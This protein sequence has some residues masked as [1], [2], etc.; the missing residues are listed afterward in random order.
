[1][2]FG[3]RLGLR[4]KIALPF[5]ITAVA[6]VVIGLFAVSTVR[7]L[8]SDTDNIADTYLPSVS[9]ILN[10]DRDL[11]QALVAQMAYVDAQSNNENGE[12]YLA[13][14]DEN[15]GQA[16]DRFNTAVGRLE[17]TGVSDVARGFDAAYERWLGSAQRVL[18]LAE[19]GTR[20]RQEP[21]QP[22]KPTTSS[23][24]SEITSTRSALT[25]THVPRFARVKPLQRARAARSPSC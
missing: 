6:L 24:I 15:A 10:G 8:V 2:D 23:T 20:S 22:A 11:Y 14:F 12:N 9:E 7:N 3:K 17:G 5:V 18:E 4:V 16:L 1:M 19:T 25:L 13:S 21:W